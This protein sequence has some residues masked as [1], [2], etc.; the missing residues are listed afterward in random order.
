MAALDAI[1]PTGPSLT[2]RPTLHR[3]R[4]IRLATHQGTGQSKPDSAAGST[5]GELRLR[6]A[7]P[8]AKPATRIGT[9]TQLTDNNLREHLTLTARLLKAETGS[10]A[11]AKAPHRP[12][13][14]YGPNALPA[15]ESITGLP[16]FDSPAGTHL[17]LRV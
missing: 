2:G 14:Q 7:S 10:N 16:L 13:Q 9:L 12:E 1:T 15:R 6:P 17:D 5:S 8:V 4:A 3:L 11:A